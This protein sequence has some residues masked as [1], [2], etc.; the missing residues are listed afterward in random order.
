VTGGESIL[1]RHNLGKNTNAQTLAGP[2]AEVNTD[3]S[4]TVRGSR[5]NWKHYSGTITLSFFD[6]LINRGDEAIS[7]LLE[8]ETRNAITSVADLLGTHLYNNGGNT[9]TNV[10]SLQDLIGAGTVQG[11][12]PSTYTTWFSRGL[13]ARNTAAASVSFAGGAFSTTG[14]SNMRLAWLNA[15]EGQIQPH[16]IYTTYDVFSAYEGS[17]QSQERFVDVN[18]PDGGFRQLAFKTAP[19]FADAKCTA[20]EM[21]FINFDALK[22]R[23]LAGADLMATDFHE[24]EIQEARTSKILLKC[25]LTINDRRLCN[26]I[27]GVTNA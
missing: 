5:S 3:P 23:V 18:T 17:L 27:T 2:W 13:S 20:G 14:I 12:N 21:H 7:S 10:S 9:A 8:F 16:A 26:K 6:E 11:I 4:D 1:I 24:A 22:L 25:Q 19:V 15:S